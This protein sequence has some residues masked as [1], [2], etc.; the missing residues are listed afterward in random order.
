MGIS[1]WCLA[2]EPLADVHDLYD[3]ANGEKMNEPETMRGFIVYLALL[4][5]GLP[6]GI[7]WTV[8]EK[9]GLGGK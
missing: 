8:K 6:M 7:Y 3:L 2:Y 1:S 5:I 9:L 4:L